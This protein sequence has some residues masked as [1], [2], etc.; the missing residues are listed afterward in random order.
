ML[1]IKK[2]LS[3]ETAANNNSLDKRK[4]FEIYKQIQFDINTLVNAEEVYKNFDNIE[5]RALIYQKYLISENIETKLDL[6]FLLKIYSRK[7]N[8]QIFIL[9]F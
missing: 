3:L 7:I 1:K 9:N 6:L 5:S 4:I 8:C 2:K